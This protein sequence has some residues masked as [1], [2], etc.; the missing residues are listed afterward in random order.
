MRLAATVLV[1]AIGCVASVA[2]QEPSAADPVFET[3]LN[4]MQQELRGAPPLGRDRPQTDRSLQ[5]WQ[6]ASVVMFEK[7]SN[8]SWKRTIGQ[9][10]ALWK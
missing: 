1:I 9:T 6:H 8:G 2:A 4:D 3:A 10:G 7:Q 5:P